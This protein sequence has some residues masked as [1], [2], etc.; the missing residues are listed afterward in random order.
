[1]SP[2]S[3]QTAP[4]RISGA[5]STP[6]SHQVQAIRAGTRLPCR[7]GDP[8]MTPVSSREL[9]SIH[10]SYGAAGIANQ[11]RGP[12]RLPG[13]TTCCRRPVPSPGRCRQARRGMGGIRAADDGPPGTPPPLMLTGAAAGQLWLS[14]PRPV[15]GL[16]PLSPEPGARG[17]MGREQNPGNA[18]I[19]AVSPGAQSARGFMALWKP[20]IPPSS[21]SLFT[22]SKPMSRNRT[23][24]SSAE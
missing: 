15:N 8:T 5:D 24:N 20:I 11:G 6:P 13:G 16:C 14:L 12:D 4:P 19:R 10:C 18:S 3:C 22:R 23:E 7:M 9:L 21:V 2:T 1:M 17:P